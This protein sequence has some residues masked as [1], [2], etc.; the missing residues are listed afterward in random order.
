MR[1]MICRISGAIALLCVPAAANAHP[2]VW[3][4]AA[5]QFDMKDGKIVSVTQRWEF[6]HMFGAMLAS[7][8]D[9][10]KDKK[11]SKPEI[12]LMRKKAFHELRNHSYFTHLRIGGKVGK[13]S[14]LPP[15]SPKYSAKTSS[16]KTELVSLA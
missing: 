3:I 8:F 16:G 10:D 2:H 12:A 15:T 1:R 5:V 4:G 6:D 11:L 13:A 9:A 14:G 7:S